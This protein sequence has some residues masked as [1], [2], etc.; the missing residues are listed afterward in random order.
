MDY[1]TRA[2]DEIHR[3]AG[4]LD[5]PSLRRETDGK[6]SPAQVLEHL[7]LAFTANRA[8]L[9][10]AL[11]SGEVRGR[12]PGLKQWLARIM[13]VDLGYFPPVQA[14]EATV[15]RGMIAP[16]RSVAAACEAL[17]ALDAAFARIAERFGHRARVAN[18]MYLGG[19]TVHQW[20]KFHWRHVR[21]H[22]KSL[23]HNP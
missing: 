21:H 14:P 5:L 2:R 7:T 18:H 23:I 9:E 12:A 15:P 1:L 4:R 8:V 19:M 13:V 22:M 10:K 17:T 6:W 20:R 16:E 3:T 11:A